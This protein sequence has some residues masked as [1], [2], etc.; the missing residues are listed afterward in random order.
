MLA[1]VPCPAGC[2]RPHQRLP[3]GSAST[4]R[5]ASRQLASS[6]L[7]ISVYAASELSLRDPQDTCYPNDSHDF[8]AVCRLASYRLPTDADGAVSTQSLRA[9]DSTSRPDSQADFRLGGVA[10]WQVQGFMLGCLDCSLSLS[11]FCAGVGQERCRWNSGARPG[12]H[13]GQGW[14]A[15]FFC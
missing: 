15:T 11:E 6:P 8:R 5:H 3:G 9:S 13:D 10:A 7:A 12:F 1:A 4:W 2:L 14:E